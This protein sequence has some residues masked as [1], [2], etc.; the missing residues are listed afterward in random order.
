MRG[1]MKKLICCGSKSFGEGNAKTLPEEGRVRV[2][3]GNDRETQCK[4][5]MEANFLN[6]PLFE[7]MLRL[8]EEEFGF[9]Y[10]GALR[11]ACDV[12]VFMH[13]IHLLKSSDPSAHYMDLHDLLSKFHTQSNNGDVGSSNA[14]RRRRR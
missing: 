14:A 9:S 3:V 12:D 11:I 10:D 13:L 1:A 6:H 7:E 8:S 4:L 2:Y 5:E